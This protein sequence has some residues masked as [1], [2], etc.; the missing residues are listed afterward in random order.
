MPRPLETPAPRAADSEAAR[1]YLSGRSYGRLRRTVVL[2]TAAVSILPLV[3]ISFLYHD[4]Y[5]RSLRAETID[6]LARQVTNSKRTLEFFLTERRSA[7]SFIVRDHSFAELCDLEALPRI[8]RS[9]N[10]AFAPGSFADLGLVDAGGRQL[11]YSGPYDLKGRDYH[12]QDWFYRVT[13]RGVFIS[14]VFLG[15]RNNPHFAIATRHERDRSGYYILRA[16][17]NADVLAEQLLTGGL[18]PH[19]DVFV[20]NRDG[21]LQ[22]P[23]RR[24]GA[25]LRTVPLK[26]PYATAE[27][28]VLE[29][30]DERHQ[31]IVLGIAQIAD[32]PFILV[33]IR[34]QV[35]LKSGGLSLPRLLAFLLLSIAVILGVI[36]WGSRQFVSN[37]RAE[38]LRRAELMHKV[39][40]SNKLATVG[41]LAAGVAHEINNPL[42]IINEKAGL[43]KDLVN[44]EAEFPR[45]DKV[46]GIVDS[47]LGSVAR[48]RKV[49]HR[50]LGFAKHMDVQ[51][52]TIAVE[53]LL[54]EVVGFLGKEAE[55]RN[56]TITVEAEPGV[57]NVESDRGQLQQVFLNI[58][59]NA[60]AAVKDGGRIDIRVHAADERRVAVSITDDGVGISA[61]NLER[62]FEPFFTTQEGA[63][64]GLGLSIT[65]GIVQKLGGDITVE[66]EIGK[67]T[68]FT[69]LLPIRRKG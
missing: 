35:R 7:L 55:Y 30:E 45:R 53:E 47:V 40:Y 42:T 4:Q 49:T 6:G 8:M 33:S 60:E 43:L 15:Y 29:L 61:D 23:S 22:A 28:Q 65:Y 48:C 13:R 39:E 31:P 11:C 64:T 25:V 18:A 37:L 51:S 9:M 21:V 41:R 58:L 17:I 20:V 27:V 3:I 1:P 54:R 12:D 50:L 52:E 5:E 57:P 36:L 69:V 34:P 56:V 44:L 24:Y 59:N 66:S 19:D 10:E 26:I 14:D 62:I 63:G 68:C 2:A 32:S 16:T 46:L 67:G 38:N